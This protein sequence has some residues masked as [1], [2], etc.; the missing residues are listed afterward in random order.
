[1]WSATLRERLLAQIA[2]VSGESLDESFAAVVQA[3][4]P[5][6]ADACVI[7]LLG[8]EEWPLPEHVPVTARRAVSSTRH[9][10]PARPPLRDQTVVI[11]DTVR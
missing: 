8:H 9:G 1:T 3:I 2:Q 6:L 4:V 10:L 5:E 11:S 7:M